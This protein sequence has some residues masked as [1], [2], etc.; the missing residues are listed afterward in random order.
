LELSGFKFPDSFSLL[1]RSLKHLT[2]DLTPFQGGSV[3]K[4]DIL[5]A[6]RL[7]PGL[8]TLHLTI[9]CHIDEV[10]VGEMRDK[11]RGECTPVDLA[12]LS[13]LTLC[14]YPAACATLLENIRTPEWCTFAFQVKGD[15]YKADD[16]PRTLSALAAKLSL[17]TTPGTRPL[18][19]LALTPERGTT[20]IVIRVWDV[21]LSSSWELLS[22]ED[23]P[24]EKL[25]I[26]IPS[27]LFTA[28]FLED[29]LERLPLLEVRSMWL[30]HVSSISRTLVIPGPE[31]PGLFRDFTSLESLHVQGWTTPRLANVLSSR[32]DQAG[33]REEDGEEF[34]FPHLRTLQLVNVQLPINS[35]DDFGKEIDHD[36]QLVDTIS[37][38]TEGGSVLKN[39]ILRVCH[40][41][42]TT[43]VRRLREVVGDVYWDG[44]VRSGEIPRWDPEA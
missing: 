19:S 14:G 28:P 9:E 20:F 11:D 3:R 18:Q 21:D 24:V 5:D 13:E 12:Q 37:R 35:V 30:K 15:Q 31:L 17:S 4:R 38:R 33:V 27:R 22:D 7:V 41:V 10:E 40:G 34:L 8:E 26:V 39:V 1:R 29:V 23:T 44:I 6:F 2:L 36:Q 32:R 25:R 43:T 42:E 16:T